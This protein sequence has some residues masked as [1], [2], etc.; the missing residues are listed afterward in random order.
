MTAGQKEG[1]KVDTRRTSTNYPG[2]IAEKGI[3]S[4]A[5]LTDRECVTYDH[6]PGFYKNWSSREPSRWCLVVLSLRGS[7][8]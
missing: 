3:V 5:E 1:A 7:G 4:I 2:V 6:S 8:A